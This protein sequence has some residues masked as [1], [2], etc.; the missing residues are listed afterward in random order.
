VDYDKSNISS[1]YNRGRDHGPA[2]LE[3]WMKT[4]ATYTAPVQVLR[5]VDLGCGTGRFSESISARLDTE[6]IGIDPSMK[7]LCEARR[8]LK[9]SRV[10][11]A[12]GCAEALPLPSNSVDLVFISMAFHH[13]TNPQ[14]AAEE[15]NRVVRENGRVFMRTG[16]RDRIPQYPYVPFFPASRILLEQ[17]LPTLA[18]QR[19]MFES[20]GFTTLFSEIVIQQ[21][22]ADYL[23]YAEKLSA[24][25]DSILI[26]LD[27]DHFESGLTALREAARMPHQS[28][29]EPIDVLVFGKN[30]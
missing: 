20:A 7:M 11:Y 4:I 19:H 2:F 23:A 24:R 26:D 9:D 10:F 17:R 5:V 13:F 30:P 14:L 27:D 18:S 16:S 25:A 8:A 3:L 21:I 1:T 29:T 22:A 12:R 28:V 6:V 15:C